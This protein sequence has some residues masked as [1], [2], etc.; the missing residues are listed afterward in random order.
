MR[1]FWNRGKKRPV[2]VPKELLVEDDV[3]GSRLGDVSGTR[4]RVY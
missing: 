3:E 4:S 2:G 1:L